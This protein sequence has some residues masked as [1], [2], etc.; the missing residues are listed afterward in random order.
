MI[1]A[2]RRWIRVIVCSM[3]L[4]LP[5]FRTP[6]RCHAEHPYSIYRT[7]SE[8]ARSGGEKS[9]VRSSIV[10]RVVRYVSS[11]NLPG[12]WIDRDCM[13]E[14]DVV[15]HEIAIYSI[16]LIYR[17]RNHPVVFLTTPIRI[18][19]K[20]RLLALL[21]RERGFNVLSCIWYKFAG[22]AE[23]SWRQGAGGPQNG[24]G[25]TPKL[26]RAAPRSFVTPYWV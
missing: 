23:R 3:A 13:N 17:F 20:A 16:D 6:G 25:A 24:T 21:H 5:V 2:A 26:G 18:T 11:N 4:P 14:N 1:C 19:Y 9:K 7:I 8:R 10:S 15:E 12:F 22:R